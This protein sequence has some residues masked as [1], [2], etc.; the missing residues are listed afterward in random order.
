VEKLLGLQPQLLENQGR[1]LGDGEVATPHRQS[2]VV[3]RTFDDL[4]RHERPC[5][6][7]VRVVPAAA[8]QTLG[9]V[10]RV[11]GVGDSLTLGQMTHQLLAAL[12]DGDH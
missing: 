12:G 5:L 10:H 4:V 8:D 2:H 1:N 3:V 7:D 9:T 6:L 11:L